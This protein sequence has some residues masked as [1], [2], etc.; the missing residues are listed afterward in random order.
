MVRGVLWVKLIKSGVRGKILN[1]IQ[2]MYN[3]INSRVTFDNELS[4]DFVEC[5]GVR[6]GKCLSPF[7]FSMMYLNDLKKEFIE[8]GVYGLDFGMLKV[9]LLLYADGIVIFSYYI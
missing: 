3:Y 2:A 5:I 7:L 4:N 1:A 6:R 8:K 9:Y